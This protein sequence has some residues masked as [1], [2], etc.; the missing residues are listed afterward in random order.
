MNGPDVE[1][2][3]EV[4]TEG[5]AQGT[6]DNPDY[7][8]VDVTRKRF[9]HARAVLALHGGHVVHALAGGSYLVCWRHLSREC[10]DLA[11][12]E[13]HARRVGAGVAS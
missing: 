7:A 10:R 1:A 2:P 4:G 9:E 5:R 8:V 12:L 3:G 13:A 11:E 6:A